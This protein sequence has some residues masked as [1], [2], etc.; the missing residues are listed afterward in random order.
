FKDLQSLKMHLGSCLSSLRTEIEREKTA[1][2]A[3]IEKLQAQLG[4][5]RD[6]ERTPPV[7]QLDPVTE[8][9]GVE[10]CRI[11]FRQAVEAGTRHY[12]VAMVVNRV[13]RINARFGREAGNRMLCR[14][15]EHVEHQFFASDRLFRWTGPAIVALLERAEAFDLVRA[16]VRRMLDAP[17]EENYEIGERSVLIPISAAWSLSMLTSAEATEQQIQTFVASQGGREFSK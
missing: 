13:Q 12:A 17:V 8:L 7:Q 15:K 5:F 1:S 9:P 4:S 3:L 14:F 16:Q 6:P 2:E 10:D 11:A